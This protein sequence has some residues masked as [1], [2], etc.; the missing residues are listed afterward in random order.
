ML[1]QPISCR[2]V[3]HL[4]Y[5]RLAYVRVA[6]NIVNKEG[7][8]CLF[9]VLASAESLNVRPGFHC[10]NLSC[11]ECVVVDYT[12]AWILAAVSTWQVSDWPF[13]I[14]E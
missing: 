11:M 8:S 9:A 1:K 7:Y 2:W 12:E 14:S 3:K 5:A 4:V 13:W 10:E 6:V